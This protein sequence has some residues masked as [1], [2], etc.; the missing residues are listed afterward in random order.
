MK[1]DGP[2]GLY[3]SFMVNTV[4][5]EFTESVVKTNKALRGYTNFQ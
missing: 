1:G 3:E 4:T 2:S 5:Y